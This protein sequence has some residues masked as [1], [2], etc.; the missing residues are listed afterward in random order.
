MFK[1]SDKELIQLLQNGTFKQRE[2]AAKQVVDKYESKLYKYVKRKFSPINKHEIEDIIWSS[3]TKGY[4]KITDGKMT[5]DN[6]SSYLFEITFRTAIAAKKSKVARQNRFNIFDYRKKNRN[7]L[8]DIQ[9]IDLNADYK[10]A[11]NELCETCQDIIQKVLDGYKHKEIA[12]LRRKAGKKESIK[13]N[14][15]RVKSQ[16]C[17]RDLLYKLKDWK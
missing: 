3:I 12:E 9:K 10:V 14:Q 4:N 17:F 1:K 5:T 8:S 16:K 15:V 2:A 6:L 13:T 7:N 11:L